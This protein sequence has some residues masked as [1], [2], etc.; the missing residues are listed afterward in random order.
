LL[1][2]IS[3]TEKGLSSSS[4][5]SDELSGREALECFIRDQSFAQ[6][7]SLELTGLKAFLNQKLITMQAEEDATIDTEFSSTNTVAVV[8]IFTHL[9][10]VDAL[11]QKLKNL[12]K[13]LHSQLSSS[14][15]SL[16]R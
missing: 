5:D 1:T 3:C 14:T 12:R 15:S 6:E 9:K 13:I 10:V 2:C 7:L 8:D 4:L 11:T 16:N